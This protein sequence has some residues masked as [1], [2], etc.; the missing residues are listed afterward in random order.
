MFDVII[1]IILQPPRSTLFPYTTLFRS[2]TM[3]DNHSR[4]LL[5]CQ[6]MYRPGMKPTRTCY[7]RAFIDYGLPRAIR[8][9]N[10]PPFASIA[11]GGLNALS[12]W[13]L[14]LGVLPER[15]APGKPQQNGRHERMHRTL[16]AATAH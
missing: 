5:C 4:F 13:L 10:G 16:K 1:I 9:D 3:T 8:T 2:L 7:E 12:V 11:L 14:K 15:I 6:G